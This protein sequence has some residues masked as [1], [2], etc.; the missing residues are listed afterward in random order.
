YGQ[1]SPILI[2]LKLRQ[3]QHQ[4]AQ[5]PHWVIRG[6]IVDLVNRHPLRAR[7]MQVAGQP[8]ATLAGN[9]ALQEQVQK[10]SDNVVVNRPAVFFHEFGE[11]AAARK[12]VVLR[13]GQSQSEVLPEEQRLPVE[14]GLS[15][16]PALYR[17]RIAEPLAES[18]ERSG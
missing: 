16:V 3:S 9:V 17:G 5:R 1:R 8:G 12:G 2:Q 15:A 6:D 11:I 7:L 13:R 18:F 10:E 4:V 14:P